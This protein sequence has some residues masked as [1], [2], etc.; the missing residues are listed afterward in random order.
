MELRVACFVF[1]VLRNKFMTAFCCFIDSNIESVIVFVVSDGLALRRV[2]STRRPLSL[3]VRIN[4]LRRLR[5][6]GLS[7]RPLSEI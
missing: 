4:L 7:R 2:A 6:I 5:S 1:S 3:V